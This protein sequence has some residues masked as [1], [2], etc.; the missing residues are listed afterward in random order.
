MAEQCKGLPIEWDEKT[1]RQMVECVKVLSGEKLLV[2]FGEGMER[3]VW[4]G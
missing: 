3:E 1:V 2:I 4:I